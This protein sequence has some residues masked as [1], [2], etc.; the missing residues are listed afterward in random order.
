MSRV[1][2]KM[3]K[4]RAMNQVEKAGQ[5]RVVYPK[6]ETYMMSEE[7]AEEFVESGFGKIVITKKK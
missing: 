2:V 5:D 6:G 3:A 7:Q 4:D 1:K